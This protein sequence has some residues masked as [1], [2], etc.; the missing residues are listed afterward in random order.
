MKTYDIPGGTVTFRDKDELNVS[1]SRAITL[2]SRHLSKKTFAK[3]DA[4]T[5]D[6][7]DDASEEE[8]TASLTEKAKIDDGKDLL[9]FPIDLEDS[10]IEASWAYNDT[11]VI[12]YLADWTLDRPL[13]RSRDELAEL[14]MPVY[15][16][17]NE[18][19]AQHVKPT[20]DGFSVDA[21]EDQT[22]PTGA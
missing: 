8:I 22:S 18:A 17:L 20:V 7:P 2:A 15:K 10:E 12:A 14:P 5:S 19:I 21:V 16:G 9:G 13:P 3:I 4:T 6:L 11:L 1:H